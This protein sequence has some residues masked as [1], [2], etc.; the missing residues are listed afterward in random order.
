V[1]R[2]GP[3][4][5]TPVLRIDVLRAKGGGLV[6][7]AFPPRPGSRVGFNPATDAMLGAAFARAE[8]R[9][10]ADLVAGK[11]FAAFRALLPGAPA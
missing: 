1:R 7:C 9:L 2:I 6:F 4:V 5:P 10:T 11:G 8:A 3:A